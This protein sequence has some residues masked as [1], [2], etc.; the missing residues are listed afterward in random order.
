[1]KY[2]LIFS[3]LLIS[4]SFS[5]VLAQKFPG[6]LQGTWKVENSEIYE[7]WD[8]INEN[9]FKG[10][11]YKMK[12]GKIQV[13]E[14]LEIRR[15]DIDVIYTATV[16]NQNQGFGIDFKLIRSDSLYS[17]EN[18]GHDFPKFVRYQL[19]SGNKMTAT[20]G[21]DEDSFILNF[22]KVE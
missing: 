6:F 13:T 5:R 19:I 12:N 20:V 11:S 14:Y 18:P 9:N 17:F 8:K 21:T 15:V 7:H 2:R 16:L 10:L 1:M 22:Q 4:A 3:I